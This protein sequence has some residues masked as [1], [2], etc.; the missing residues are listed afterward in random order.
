MFHIQRCSFGPQFQLVMGE[1]RAIEGYLADHGW[2]EV[3]LAGITDLDWEDILEA[4]KPAVGVL[5]FG[6]ELILKGLLKRAE[7]RQRA[8]NTAFA[9]NPGSFFVDTAWQNRYGPEAETP[10]T[11]LLQWEA[12]KRHA[13]KPKWPT[14]F[15]RNLEGT[16][17]VTSR[18][19]L[20]SRERDRVVT[21]LG[22]V[23]VKAGLAPPPDGRDRDTLGSQA[24]QRRYAMGRRLGTLRQHVRN[25]EKMTRFCMSS[26][27][28]SWFKQA[29]DYYDLVAGRLSEPCG[30]HVPRALLNS[31]AFAEQAA[32]VPEDQRLSKNAGVRNFLREMECSRSWLQGRITKKAPPF[33]LAVVIALED[34]VMRKEEKAFV[35]FFAWIKLL[36]L[37]ASFRWDD[38]QGVP[39]HLLRLRA[40]GVLEGQ[41]VRSKTTGA[42]KKVEILNFFIDPMCYLLREEWLMTGWTLN[43]WMSRQ[44]GLENRD[45]LVP[46]ASSSLDGFCK[47][48]VKYSDAMSMTRALFEKM[49]ADVRVEEGDQDILGPD[50]SLVMVDSVG[51]WTEHSERGTLTTWGQIARIPPESRR[52][53]GRW[54]ASQDEG[55][56]RNLEAATRGAQRKIADMI[57][58]SPPG[59]LNGLED[60][61]F[62]E[63]RAYLEKRGVDESTIRQQLKHLEIPML[64]G[65]DEAKA[66]EVIPCEG[67]VSDMVPTEKASP[68]SGFGGA[69]RKSKLLEAPPDVEPSPTSPAMSVEISDP[70]EGMAGVGGEGVAEMEEKPGTYV[71]S[72]R[73]TCNRRTLHR[74]GEC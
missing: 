16:E 2:D 46:G 11:P 21:R 47:S 52:M 65:E 43:Q 18:A 48:F 56:L 51:F 55:Y 36:K 72:V 61:I 40:D 49:R 7:N 69:F 74:V 39:N 70:G 44:A 34:V 24:A 6:E 58:M 14:R 53:M 10:V 3:A 38:V 20:E 33:P 32:E 62:R 60:Q 71:F 41:L 17:G 30:R 23:L 45:F 29:R 59:K 63:L 35:R 19:E 25:L 73:G 27:G 64:E 42:G 9:R 1:C 5:S 67:S 15:Q 22:D 26:F 57:R 66:S 54:S 8:G 50:H 37:W 12:V 4:V 68:S 31:I 28:Y 13:K